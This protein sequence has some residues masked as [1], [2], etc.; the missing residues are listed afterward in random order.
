MASWRTSGPK[1]TAASLWGTSLLGQTCPLSAFWVMIHWFRIPIWMSWNWALYNT[2]MVN[3]KGTN[4]RQEI[5][6][7]YADEMGVQF[8]GLNDLSLSAMQM[9]LIC[10]LCH[11]PLM[12]HFLLHLLL[13]TLLHFPL[14]LIA[15]RW[16]WAS[17]ENVEVQLLVAWRS[18]VCTI[19]LRC[20]Y[21]FS[22]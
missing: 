22:P 5:I 6:Q 16:A 21:A 18:E 13:A 20:S 2:A 12:L 17:L 15:S 9:L 11:L 14:H 7:M 4:T 10:F 3:W 19:V 8:W 1:S